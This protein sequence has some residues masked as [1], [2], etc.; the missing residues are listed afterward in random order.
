[1]SGIFREPV[2]GDA[3]FGGWFALQA[4]KTLG[5]LLVDVYGPSH[6]KGTLDLKRGKLDFKKAYVGRD[7]SI[8]Y[9][10]VRDEQG[11]Y[12]GSY[13]GSKV[14]KGPAFCKFSEHW[15]DMNFRTI[16]A[17][18]AAREMIDLSISLG[19]VEVVKGRGGEDMLRVADKW[20]GPGQS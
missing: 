7:D 17:K 20:R 2:S 13:E 4:D 10:L 5:G 12:H 16:S 15:K 18:E 9:D 11:V 6:M 1:M 14:I 3:V 19:D 8:K